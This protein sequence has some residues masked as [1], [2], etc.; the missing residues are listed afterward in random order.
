MLLEHGIF[1]L[2]TTDSY[3][4]AQTSIRIYLTLIS[5]FIPIKR[6]FEIL[7][8]DEVHDLHRNRKFDRLKI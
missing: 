4:A 7:I 1:T 5:H 2:Y 3:D 8:T 6:I